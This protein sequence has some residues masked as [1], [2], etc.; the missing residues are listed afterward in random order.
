MRIR[1]QVNVFGRFSAELASVARV[2]VLIDYFSQTSAES[3]DLH[4]IIDT[5][6]QYPLQATEMLQ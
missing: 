6:T 5:R 2:E 1:S 3:A 4:E